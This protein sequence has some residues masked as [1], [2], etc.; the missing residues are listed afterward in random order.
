MSI[1]KNNRLS[2]FEIDPAVEAALGPPRQTYYDHAAKVRQMTPSQRRKAEY[3]QQRSKASYDL[4]AEMIEIID[5]FSE[6]YSAPRGQLAAFLIA[7]GLR[8]VI[9]GESKLSWAIQPSRGIRFLNQVN[10]SN[11][12]SVADV[13]LFL[14]KNGKL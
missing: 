13:K 1:Q 9:N 8:S 4:P 12:P 10:I 7:T 14:E 2:A 5:L 6:T 11:M 3:D